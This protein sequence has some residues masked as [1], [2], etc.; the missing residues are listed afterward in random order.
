M[1]CVQARAPKDHREEE[2]G[3]LADERADGL[4]LI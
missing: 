3:T 2:G 4:R 1:A